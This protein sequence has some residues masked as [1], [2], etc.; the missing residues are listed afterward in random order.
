MLYRADYLIIS[1]KQFVFIEFQG[2]SKRD[3]EIN[4]GEFHNFKNT[5]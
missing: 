5:C 4:N 3:A 1:N 2:I